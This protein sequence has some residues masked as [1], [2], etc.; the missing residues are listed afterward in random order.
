M[1]H[2]GHESKSVSHCH[3]C[4][5]RPD[6]RNF[7]R[8]SLGIFRKL[9][10]RSQLSYLKLIIRSTNTTRVT[11]FYAKLVRKEKLIKTSAVFNTPWRIQREI[12]DHTCCCWLHR[13]WPQPS[14][15]TSFTCF[16]RTGDVGKFAGYHGKMIVLRGIFNLQNNKTFSPLYMYDLNTHIRRVKFSVSK[17]L[18]DFHHNILL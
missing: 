8:K 9:R 2:V 17:T 18:S 15:V 14:M 13:K 4:F 5:L 6:F 3:L 1:G 12:N 10:L 7:L 16:S 11:S